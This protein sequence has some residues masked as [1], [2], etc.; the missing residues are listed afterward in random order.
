M[1]SAQGKHFPQMNKSTLH[2]FYYTWST[3]LCFTL[4]L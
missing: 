2:L 1:D 3:S 4:L